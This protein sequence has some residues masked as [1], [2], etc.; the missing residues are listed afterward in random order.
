MV[1]R[2]GV[3]GSGPF[4]GGDTTVTKSLCDHVPAKTSLLL[5]GLSEQVIA[6]ALDAEQA[7]PRDQEGRPLIILFAENAV[8]SWLPEAYGKAAFLAH[9]V[10]GIALGE[11]V[12]SFLRGGGRA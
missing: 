11:A 6:A 12:G 1:L 10:A 7:I 5:A 3:G 2:A 4:A 9:M 8:P